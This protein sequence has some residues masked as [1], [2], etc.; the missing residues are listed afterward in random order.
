VR[1]EKE[2]ELSRVGIRFIGATLPMYTS[3]SD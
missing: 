1:V 2:G 3:E